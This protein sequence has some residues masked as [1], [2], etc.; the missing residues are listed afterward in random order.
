MKKDKIKRDGSDF[1]SFFGCNFWADNR[2][3]S[4]DSRIKPAQRILGKT[5][6]WILGASQ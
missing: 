1:C 5:I 2:R 4:S 6:V 3:G